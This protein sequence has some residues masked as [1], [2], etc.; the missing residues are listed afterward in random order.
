MVGSLGNSPSTFV[1][2]S[3]PVRY[4]W[5]VLTQASAIGGSVLALPHQFLG[6]RR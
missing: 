3:E 6:R 5:T 1:S 4:V 2:D